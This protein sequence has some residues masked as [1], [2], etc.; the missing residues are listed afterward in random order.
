MKKCENNTHD[1]SFSN[2]PNKPDFGKIYI[3]E[4]FAKMSDEQLIEIILSYMC[5]R[6]EYLRARDVLK[7]IVDISDLLNLDALCM[8]FGSCS[9]DFATFLKT[10][11]KLFA[12][13]NKTLK[14]K[15]SVCNDALE[16]L[17]KKELESEVTENFCI[18]FLNEN[19]KVVFSKKY[20]SNKIESIYMDDGEIANKIIK[21]GVSKISVAHNHPSGSFSFSLRDYNI[22]KAICLFLK[23]LKIKMISHYIVSRNG[24]VKTSRENILS[25]LNDDIKENAE[26]KTHEKE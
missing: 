25:F 6:K 11:K 8:A 1:R 3:R 10:L 4:E 12:L 9:L 18:A 5:S 19:E 21:L 14:K 24:C 7:D 15:K 16:E 26:E 22:I 13:N 17:F 23:P 20:S 2:E